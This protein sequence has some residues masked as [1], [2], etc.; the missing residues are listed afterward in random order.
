MKKIDSAKPVE[1]IVLSPDQHNPSN[2]KILT[3]SETRQPCIIIPGH[4]IGHFIGKSGRF[5][6]DIRRTYHVSYNIETTHDDQGNRI[7]EIYINGHNFSAAKAALCA[8]ASRLNEVDERIRTNSRY[9][10]HPSPPVSSDETPQRVPSASA[11]PPLPSKNIPEQPKVVAPEQPSMTWMDPCEDAP[12]KMRP[13]DQLQASVSATGLV[14]KQLRKALAAEQS[15]VT[16]LVAKNTLLHA[17]LHKEREMASTTLVIRGIPKVRMTGESFGAKALH[18]T[19]AK[20]GDITS[21]HLADAVGSS[22]K[23]ICYVTFAERR[24]AVELQKMLHGNKIEGSLMR[25]HFFVTRWD[26]TS[27]DTQRVRQ[28]G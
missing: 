24:T 5:A 3:M 23:Q 15:K 14:I 21:L 13:I 12:R 26:N 8:E 2:K 17:L 4:W 19:L 20:A 7:G 28:N 18:E 16:H 11:F 25:V 9:G 27:G 22:D 1:S 10:Q 6:A